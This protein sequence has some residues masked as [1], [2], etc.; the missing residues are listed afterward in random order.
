MKQF[1]IEQLRS[2]EKNQMNE[3]SFDFSQV[4]QWID[5]MPKSELNKTRKEFAS[6]VSSK[7]EGGFRKYLQAKLMKSNKYVEVIKLVIN[8]MQNKSKENYNAI[9]ELIGIPMLDYFVQKTFGKDSFLGRIKQITPF[10]KKVSTGNGKLDM[11]IYNAMAEALELKTVRDTFERDMK[12]VLDDKMDSL[13]TD[14]AFWDFFEPTQQPQLPSGDTNES[15]N[16][17]FGINTA[18]KQGIS[19]RLDRLKAVFSSRETKNK[20]KILDSITKFMPNIKTDLKRKI[21]E[22]L[23]DLNYDDISDMVE[24]LNVSKAAKIVTLPVMQNIIKNSQELYFGEPSFNDFIDIVK[25]VFTDKV[26]LASVQKGIENFLREMVKKAREEQQKK[27]GFK[28]SKSKSY[29]YDRL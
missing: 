4:D 21:K 18:I 28:T 12:N 14:Q 26:V 13:E 9:F 7:F 25:G 24:R 2:I 23:F 1:I 10:L 5:S 29:D 27:G 19:N 15:I 17:V 3:D 11:A 22:R 6:L 8:Y 20:F 16:E